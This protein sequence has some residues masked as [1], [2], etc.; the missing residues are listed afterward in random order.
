MDVLQEIAENVR[1]GEA[2]KVSELV[3]KGLD[4]GLSWEVLLNKGCLKGWR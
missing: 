3:Q 1:Y 2:S 4:D